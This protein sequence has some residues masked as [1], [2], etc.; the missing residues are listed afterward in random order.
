MRRSI[1]R[2][3]ICLRLFSA[4]AAV[5][6]N[7]VSTTT[8]PSGATSMPIVPPRPVKMPTLPRKGSN[9]VCGGGGA[10]GAGVWPHACENVPRATDDVANNSR[11]LSFITP[12]MAHSI[13]SGM[14]EHHHHNHGDKHAVHLALVERLRRQAAEVKRLAAG[15]DET[16]LATRS[17]PGKWS[18]KEIICHF[19]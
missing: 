10:A 16:A 5:S 8:T 13:M 2:A 19:R 9:E 12:P 1:V 18:M 17:V 15:L 4:I 7:C 14:S 11:R 6:A 3:L